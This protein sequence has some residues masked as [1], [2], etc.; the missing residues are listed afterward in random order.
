MSYSPALVPA[1]SSVEVTRVEILD[2]NSRY[3]MIPKLADA[4]KLL[5]EDEY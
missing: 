4:H 1:S 3:A 2:S 5:K